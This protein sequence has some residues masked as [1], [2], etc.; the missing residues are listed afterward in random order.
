[1]IYPRPL[2]PGDAIAILSPASAIKNELIDSACATLRSWGFRPVVCAHSKGKWGSYS[3]TVEERLADIHDALAD[4]SVRAILCAR[5]GYG[6]VH[7]LEHF[8]PGLWSRDPK[9]VMGFSDISA[10]HAAVAMDGVASIHSPMCKHLTEH[11]DDEA[12]CSLRAIL[13][14][15][16]PDYTVDA[17]PHNRKGE[18][19]G[20]IY[21]G[22]IAVLSGLLSTKYN[23]LR[24]DHILFIEDIDEEIYS[25]ER[26]LYHLRLSGVLESTRALIVGQ[27]TDYKHPSKDFDNMYDM[28]ERMVAD[29]S[30]PVAY[31]FP[32]G[33]VDYN[34]PIV[35]GAN[36]RL[37]VGDDHVRLTLSR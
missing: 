35:E 34:L 6:V 29:Y 20:Q 27:F 14:G 21:G 13:T 26:M 25:I 8:E 19:E 2:Q 30:F 28:V 23:L 3:G 18:A 36:A 4:P 24:K 17:D 22:N 9:W 7:L 31:N 32:V 33:H 12:S 10:F 37:T 1:M 5:G 15:T 16:M 11:P